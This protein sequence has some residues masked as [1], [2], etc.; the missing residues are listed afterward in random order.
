MS[1][2]EQSRPVVRHLT[3]DENSSGQRLDNFLTRELKGV[4]R[5]RLYRALRKGEI[6]VNKGRVKADYRLVTGDLVRIPPLRTPAPSDPPTIPR[7]WSEQLKQRVI[8]EDGGLLVVDKPSGLAVHGGSGLNFGMIESLRQIRSE[9]RYL[10]LVH[11]LDRDTSGLIMVARKPAI[12]RELHRQLREDHVDKRYLALVAGKWPRSKVRVDAPLQKNV[13]QSG[14]RMVRVAKEGKR[15]ITDFTVVERFK[16]A[17]LVEAKPVTGR[18]H[19]IRVHALH[20]G[21]P[22]LGDSKYGSPKGEALCEQIGLKRLFLHA[23]A[24]RF[25]LP[26]VGRMELEAPLDKDLEM[27]LDKLRKWL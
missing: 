26:D 23:R 15:S 2:S 4:P 25:K 9:D 14:E 16:G 5:T 24:L 11:R 20:A 7:Y 6:R 17:T 21:F 12:L 13:L 19:Q 1:E 22:L 8:Y 27:A 10:E 3:V 18:T